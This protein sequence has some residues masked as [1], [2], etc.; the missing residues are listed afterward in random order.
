MFCYSHARQINQSPLESNEKIPSELL[1]LRDPLWG[2]TV[3][4]NEIVWLSH[5][6]SRA[7][8]FPDSSSSVNA[9]PGQSSSSPVCALPPLSPPVSCLHQNPRTRPGGL[10]VPGQQQHSTPSTGCSRKTH[11]GQSLVCQTSF[12]ANRGSTRP[13]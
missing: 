3:S 13:I 2:G 7:V 10:P 1:L 6:L 11:L 8:P 9:R 12:R 5:W 4:A